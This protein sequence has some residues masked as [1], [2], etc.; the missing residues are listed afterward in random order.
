MTGCRH[1]GLLHPPKATWFIEMMWVK[2]DYFQ[3]TI[4]GDEQK[5]LK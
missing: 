1:E 5:D 3:T 4:G 2:Q